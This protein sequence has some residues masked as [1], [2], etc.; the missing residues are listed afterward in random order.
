MMFLMNAFQAHCLAFGN[1]LCTNDDFAV[2]GLFEF[3]ILCS[4][5]LFDLTDTS[6]SLLFCVVCRCIVFCINIWLFLVIFVL[7]YN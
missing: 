1:I 7:L 6:L 3:I 2:T 4:T 5:S